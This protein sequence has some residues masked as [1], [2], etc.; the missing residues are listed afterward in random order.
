MWNPVVIC[1]QEHLCRD[2]IL[3]ASAGSL[4]T[5]LSLTEPGTGSVR[6]RTVPHRTWH[7][8]GWFK[9]SLNIFDRMELESS[10][11]NELFFFPVGL[12]ICLRCPENSLISFPLE[13]GRC[14]SEPLRGQGEG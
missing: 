9:G 3:P 11:K 1:V 8:L 13:A 2:L 10:L 14:G 6:D 4:R 7:R 12:Q 5:V